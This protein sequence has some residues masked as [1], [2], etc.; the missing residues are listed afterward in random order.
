MGFVSLLIVAGAFGIFFYAGECGYSVELARTMV[1][2]T[3]V[4]ME[5]FYLFNVRYIHG[6]SLTW[7]GVF[8][9]PAVLI[10]LGVVLVAQLA[11]T[12]MPSMQAVFGTEPIK[13]LDGALI[14]GIGVALLIVVEIEKF[15][16]AAVFEREPRGRRTALDPR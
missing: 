10:A 14:V 1:V 11:F 8:G 7:Q 16:V 9:T 4:A 2:N 5:A 13:L 3:I 6:T 15:I 12:Y